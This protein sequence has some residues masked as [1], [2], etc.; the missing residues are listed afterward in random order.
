MFVEGK[1]N[2]NTFTQDN[3]MLSI[4]ITLIYSK[5]FS[6]DYITMSVNIKNHCWQTQRFDSPLSLLS[7]SVTIKCWLIKTMLKLFSLR[8]NFSNKM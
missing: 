7:S 2:N 8:N 1:E 4:K 6:A 5:L 3:Y